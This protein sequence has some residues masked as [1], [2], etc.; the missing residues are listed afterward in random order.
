[1]PRMKRFLLAL[2]CFFALASTPSRTRADLG[3]WTLITR[4]GPVPVARRGHTM[5]YDEPRDRLVVFGGQTSVG[6]RFND[7]WVLPLHPDS[8]WRLLNPTGTAPSTRYDHSAIY[9]PVD[10]RM[11]VFGGQG[12][13]LLN[14]VWALSL[15]GTPTWTQITVPGAPIAARSGHAAFYDGCVAT[16]RMI[17]YGGAAQTDIRAL[18]LSGSFPWQNLTPPGPAPAAGSQVGSAV[19]PSGNILYVFSN[20]GTWSVDLDAPAGWA[21]ETTV[22]TTPSSRTLVYSAYNQDH[23]ALL[24]FGGIGGTGPLSE[25]WTLGL[26]AG[27]KQWQKLSQTGPPPGKRYNGRGFYDRL[28]SRLLV[29][30]GVDS[31]TVV[32]NQLWSLPFGPSSPPGPEPVFSGTLDEWHAARAAARASDRGAGLSRAAVTVCGVDTCGNGFPSINDVNFNAE[33]DHLAVVTRLG[34]ESYSGWPV[35]EIIDLTAGS[36]PPTTGVWN[37]LTRYSGPPGHEWT[38]YEMPS[39][40]G[41]T[42]DR[43]GNIFVA[44]CGE[45]NMVDFWSSVT[46]PA[47]VIYKIDAHTGIPAVFKT[48][49]TVESIGNITYDPNHHQLFVTALAMKTGLANHIYRID[50]NTGQTLEDYSPFNQVQCFAMG[51]NLNRIWGIAWHLG[52]VYYAVQG[53]DDNC[54]QCAG[55]Y[56][57][58]SFALA[59]DGSVVGGSDVLEITIPYGTVGVPYIY[60]IPDLSFSPVNGNMLV[61]TGGKYALEYQCAPGGWV[62]SG[63]TFLRAKEE[64]DGGVAYDPVGHPSTAGRAWIANAH[65]STGGSTYENGLM[66][67]PGNGGSAATSYLVTAPAQDDGAYYLDIVLPCANSCGPEKPC[68]TGPIAYYKFDDPDDLAHNYGNDLLP[69]YLGDVIPVLGHC[70]SALRFLPDNNIDEFTIYENTDL[71]LTGAMSVSAWIKVRGTQS[72]DFNPGCAEGTILTKG[73]NYWFQLS[74]DNDK[75]VYQNEG[76]GSEVAIAYYDFEPDVWTQ[77][78]F[79]RGDWVGNKQTIQLYVNGCPVQTLVTLNGVP[80]IDLHN[81]ATA[82]NYA[83]QVGNHGFGNDPG[84]CEFNGDID[85]LQIF[86]RS[87]THDEMRGIMSCPCDTPLVC[88]PPDSVALNTG[89]DDPTQ[90]LIGYG[91][92]DN[93][94]MLVSDPMAG[95]STP[96]PAS[97]IPK[98]PSWSV[99]PDSRWIGAAAATDTV[100]L[101]DGTYTFEFAFCLDDSIGALLNLCSHAAP[102][103]VI[104]LNGAAIGPTGGAAGPC[105]ALSVGNPALFRVGRNVVT[106]TITKF[107]GGALALDLT[108]A[109]YG[110]GVKYAECCYD[111]SGSLVGRVWQDN[112]AD[113]LQQS[114]EPYLANYTVTLSNG[115]T[116]VTDQFGYYAFTGLPSGTYTIGVTVPSN[117]AVSYPKSAANPPHKHKVLLD[118]GEARVDLDFGVWSTL[119]QI[120]VD[121]APLPTRFAITGVKPNPVVQSTTISYA[122]PAPADVSLQVFD[123]VGRLVANLSPGKRPAG[124]HQAEW[125]GRSANGERA[126][127]GIYMVRLRAGGQ[128]ATSRL[129]L[130]R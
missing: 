117:W 48:L 80:E 6:T 93:H 62:P 92:P 55:D 123:I 65:M 45:A 103:G 120:G 33:S 67:T 90:T 112:N 72:T 113:A 47:N 40:F 58:R 29:F 8:S 84:A 3:D 38:Y 71:D 121:P 57:I 78:G 70:G 69:A 97:V 128:V 4:P 20:G 124:V 116:R 110:S 53:N 104:S 88:A 25:T 12:T 74:R 125:N 54:H 52:R 23:H 95:F 86:D 66:A 107:G 83:V 24:M 14:D 96:R 98:D 10:Q 82:N 127:A 79:V 75:L 11:V 35:V 44:Q 130:V 73:G 106:V 91:H 42:T 41:I 99:E 1:M 49:N 30:G 109:V 56:F 61:A 18:T 81:P 22:G 2:L 16:P 76:S 68:P 39:P 126:R 43:Y 64:F 19:D 118:P 85:E 46:S 5:I 111:S 129:V 89:W 108:G 115:Q 50:A 100:A 105:G 77:V 15:T 28:R 7:V 114:S 32:T 59:G 36:G 37:G 26:G 63:N 21:T 31:T 51:R 119:V 9:D 101:A 122:L 94:W 13:T 27:P 102:P 17:I 60:S 87:L 34:P